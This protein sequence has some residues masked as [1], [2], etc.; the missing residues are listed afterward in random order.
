MKTQRNRYKL[1]HHAQRLAPAI[2]SRFL[3]VAKTFPDLKTWEQYDPI[4]L[5]M[6]RGCDLLDLPE[7]SRHMNGRE[8]I[9]K[10]MVSKSAAFHETRGVWRSHDPASFWRAWDQD[11]LEDL[12][13]TE[14]MGPLRG[15][16]LQKRAMRHWRSDLERLAGISLRIKGDKTILETLCRILV[17]TPGCVFPRDITLQGVDEVQLQSAIELGLHFEHFVDI[18]S[19]YYLKTS[20]QGDTVIY[21]DIEDIISVL[22]Q[23]SGMTIVPSGKST[24]RKES[25]PYIEDIE[26]PD[27]LTDQDPFNIVL[28]DRTYHVGKAEPWQIELPDSKA[29]DLMR[30]MAY[31][32]MKVM[33][34]RFSLLMFV[35]GGEVEDDIKENL[36]IMPEHLSDLF[37]EHFKKK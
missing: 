14:H 9:T 32:T 20:T 37:A 13:I 19:G 17:S 18:G 34:S 12:D 30:V 29:G 31:V 36:H 3:E 6:A 7:F 22:N 16:V 4:G 5:E 2:Y 35:Y 24:F 26:V 28:P 10:A 21:P 23:I 33:A 11:W 1:S 25:L 27:F 8:R 15:E